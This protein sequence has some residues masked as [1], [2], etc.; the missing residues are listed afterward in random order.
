[1]SSPLVHAVGASVAGSIVFCLNQKIEGGKI[2]TDSVIASAAFSG[3]LGLLIDA[4]RILKP[5]LSAANPSWHNLPEKPVHAYLPAISTIL[6]ASYLV[7]YGI[8]FFRAIRIMM[9]PI[10][11]VFFSHYLLDYGIVCMINSELIC[12]LANHQGEKI[13]QLFTLFGPGP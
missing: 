13:R 9:P 3:L 10:A 7:L 4:D 6:V 8:N 5:I 2:N 1:M 12:F 11:A